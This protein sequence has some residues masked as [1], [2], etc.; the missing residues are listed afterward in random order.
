M[1]LRWTSHHKG[2]DHHHT[3]ILKSSVAHTR[4]NRVKGQ[5][6]MDSHRPTNNDVGLPPFKAKIKWLIYRNYIVHFLQILCFDYNS[7]KYTNHNDEIILYKQVDMSRLLVS[8]IIHSKITNNWKE[9]QR[10]IIYRFGLLNTVL[11]ETPYGL[12]WFVR[13]FYRS[14]TRA[15]EAGWEQTYAVSDL[16]AT[17]L[18]KE[19]PCFNASWY[20]D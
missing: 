11:V 7:F 10:Y 15:V 17:A 16:S 12:M 1:H 4:T 20:N 9:L 8:I 18:T 3:V 19:V 13:W 14:Y 6:S 5:N 2:H